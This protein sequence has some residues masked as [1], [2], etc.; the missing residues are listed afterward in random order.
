MSDLIVV[1]PSNISFS[2]LAT[3]GTLSKNSNLYRRS[4]VH[5]YH[6]VVFC[7]FAFIYVELDYFIV[8]VNERPHDSKK[9]LLDGHI[10]YAARHMS[11][12]PKTLQCE[13]N[14]SLR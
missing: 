3:M 7:C 4:T 14:N 6:L 1:A 10:R 13:V 8:I 12:I 9:I 5:Y 2:D 11:R